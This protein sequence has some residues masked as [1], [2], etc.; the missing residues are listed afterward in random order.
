MHLYTLLSENEDSSD[1]DSEIKDDK[2]AE[3]QRAFQKFQVS[4]SLIKSK[5][6]VPKIGLDSE[7]SSIETPKPSLDSQAKE[8]AELQAKLKKAEEDLKK[9]QETTA[10]LRQ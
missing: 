2:T 5:T 8:I 7:I 4:N 10:S 3:S 9:E 1:Y 6:F